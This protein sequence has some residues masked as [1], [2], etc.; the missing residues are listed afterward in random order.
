MIMKDN[1]TTYSLFLEDEK[2][3]FK[4]IE[5]IKHIPHS[6][7]EFPDNYDDGALKMIYGVDYKTQ[8]LKLADLFVDY[9][10]KDIKGIE[11]KARYSRMYCDVEKHKDDKKEIMAQYG[12]GYI[13]IKN[14]FNNKPYFRN[15]IYKGEDLS[16]DIDI[17][18]DKH[19]ERLTNEI[20]RIISQ[21]KKA[22]I[23][24]LHSFSDEQATLIGKRGPFP[25]ICIG[26]NN[27]QVDG[28]IL[29][30][31]IKRIKAKG[32]S[33]KINYPY[34]G[35]IIPNNLTTKEKKCV[36]SIMI[37]VNKRIYL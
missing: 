23:L 9:L 1:K 31:I 14:I 16:K 18:Y 11:I 21:G 13:Y 36:C 5:I 17:Y 25:D 34:K 28:R 27:N 6:S 12:L 8:N 33:Y 32:Y 24:D 29:T 22:L 15:L 19:H 35:A 30:A 4:D 20:K 2:E 10:F 37:E 3:I 26:I 7:L